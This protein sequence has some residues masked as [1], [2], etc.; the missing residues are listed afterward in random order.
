MMMKIK[1]KCHCTMGRK[2]TKYIFTSTSVK[3]ISQVKMWMFYLLLQ[4]HK[5]IRLKI[6]I[7]F[8]IF[9]QCEAQCNSSRCICQGREYA[10]LWDAELTWYSLRKLLTRFT[11][12]TCSTA[13]EFTVLGLPDHDWSLRFLQPK[14]NFLNY[15][16][17]V[18][19][20]T[21]P[22]PFPQQIFLIASTELWLSFNSEL[23][24]ITDSFA[25]LS[26]HTEWSNAKCVS[27]PTI[28]ILLI[29]AGTFH[30]FSYIIYTQQTSIYQNIAKFLTH[31]S[32]FLILCFTFQ[33][34]HAIL[35]ITIGFIGYIFMVL[36]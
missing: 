35:N 4:N 23:N 16:V 21:T 26:N 5:E 36:D 19:G 2:T 3:G 27:I 13:S 25:Q 29:T 8:A 7:S 22:L 18:L 24:Y 12:I 32:S 6:S 28:I 1:S 17:T 31:L 20:S 34:K 10:E 11:S 9:W 33:I 30:S 15:L 14:K